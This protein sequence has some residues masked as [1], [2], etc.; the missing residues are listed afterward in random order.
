MNQNKNKASIKNYEETFDIFNHNRNSVKLDPNE[1]DQEYIDRIK[2][3]EKLT[4]DKNIYKEKATLEGS[5]KLM[6]NLR[7]VL[8][9]KAKIFG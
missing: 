6:T 4:L 3:L 9:D 8:R 1:G 7:N 2:S 5:R